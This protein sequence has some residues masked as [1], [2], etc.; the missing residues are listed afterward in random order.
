MAVSTISGTK[1]IYPTLNT[2][3]FK[4]YNNSDASKPIMYVRNGVVTLAGMVAPS[5]QL[6]DA[7]GHLICT[8]PE[9]YRPRFELHSIMQGSGTARWDLRITT[10]GEVLLQ[11]YSDNTVSQSL[12]TW[13]YLPF[14]ATWVI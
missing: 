13:A 6:S 5:V 14:H 1:V 3:K 10:S 7:D 12:P 11:R 8:I 2:A 9:G 4:P